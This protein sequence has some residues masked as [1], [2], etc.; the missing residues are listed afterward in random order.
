MINLGCTNKSLLAIFIL[1]FTIQ[2]SL[3]GQDHLTVKV[4]SGEHI[5]MLMERYLLK[6]YPC[7][8]LKFKSINNLKSNK[9]LANAIYKLPI[10]VYKYNSK[11]I[12]TTIGITDYEQAKRIQKYNEA[13]FHKKIRKED[14]RTG[15]KILWV[16]QH[17]VECKKIYKNEEISSTAKGRVFP[18]FGSEYQYVPLQSNKLKG[19]VFYIVSGHGGPDPGAVDRTKGW[20]MCEDE[21]AYDIALRL[22]RNLISHGATAYMIIRDPNDGIRG[23][24][25]LKHDKDEYC[26]RTSK[27][28]PEQKKRLQQRSD[29]VNKL[30]AYHKKR[31]VSDDNQKTLAIH[32]D[33]R[34]V[35]KRIDLFFYYHPNKKAGKK[36][37]TTLQQAIKAEYGKH[38]KNRN[39][40]GTVKSRD[41][42]VLREMKT[43]TAYIEL[44]NIKNKLDQQRFLKEGN[45][46]ALANWLLNGLMKA[47]AVGSK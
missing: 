34:T 9:I 42:F 36:F 26:Y 23:G 11:S 29:A 13:L 17:E 43:T 37:A 10:K 40:T 32:I 44:G 6:K 4:K 15:Q 1:L 31:G 3:L 18:I 28:P 5:N 16:P 30:Y 38:Q 14:Y 22:T 45:R 7:N 27:I 25:Q 19:K 46:Q 24:S 33:S 2:L 35:N 12:R 20:K 8:K 41:L 47:S 21:Y 39:Y